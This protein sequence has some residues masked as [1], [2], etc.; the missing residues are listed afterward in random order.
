MNENQDL[1]YPEENIFGTIIHD[2]PNQDR[3]VSERIDL[4]SIMPS[5]VPGICNL[6]RC[7]D[8]LMMSVIL[9]DTTSEFFQL[10]RIVA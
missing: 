9:T 4:M 1:R 3:P 5:A 2:A 10:R 7:R 8:R 6:M